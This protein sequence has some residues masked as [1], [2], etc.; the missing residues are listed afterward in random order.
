MARLS[1][2]KPRSAS[3]ATSR[4]ESP[5]AADDAITTILADDH[6]L[7]RE[8]MR[9]L[10]EGEPDIRVVGEADDGHRAIAL[11]AKLRPHVILMD[12]GMPR[13]NGIDAIRQVS[14]A[15]PGTRV[16]ILSAH[17]DPEY[18]ERARAYG[19]S[20]YVLKHSSLGELSGAIR[21]VRTGGPFVRPARESVAGPGVQPART[22]TSREA[23]ILQ[24]VAEGSG[25]KQAARILGISI[26][27]VEKHRQSLMTKLGIHDVAGLTRYAI[28]I[29]VIEGR[30]A[31]PAP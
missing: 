23:Q 11:A 28:S 29:G 22:L 20:G 7:V 31:P 18:V 3:R 5:R 10:L 19:A 17:A 12:I 26:K 21:V 2:A 15:S 1:G 16:I 14:T 6:T 25:N 13:L 9:C 30:E 27:T 4:A 8:G 24:F